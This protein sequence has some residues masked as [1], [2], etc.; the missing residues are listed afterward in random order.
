[1]RTSTSRRCAPF[2]VVAVASALF[3]AT[4]SS[5]ASPAPLA[6]GD[7]WRIM[8]PPPPSDGGRATYYD[9]AGTGR[10]DVWIVG[11]TGQTGSSHALI[12][13]W[14]GDAWTE[15]PAGGTQLNATLHSVAVVSRTNA[16]AVGWDY[17]PVQH[18]FEG[19]M[20]HWDGTSWTRQPTPDHGLEVFLN[21][22]AA[23]SSTRAIAVGE[24]STFSSTKTVAIRLRNG[25]WHS[26][27]TPPLGP[28]SSLSAVSMR[29]RADAWAVGTRLDPG[30][31]RHVVALHWDG[32]TWSD[33]GAPDPGVFRNALNGVD[34][35]A[36]NDVWAVGSSENDDA[37]RWWSAWHWDGSGWTTSELTGD[38]NVADLQAVA[39]FAPDD[40]R[41][42]GVAPFGTSPMR[43]A[44]WD[45]A[46]LVP[47]SV[48]SLRPT[49]EGHLYGAAVIGGR[50]WAVGDVTNATTFAQVRGLVARRC[51]GA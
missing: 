33:M 37:T 31:N 10:A 25:V 16:W 12:Q 7:A 50:L 17:D 18:R 11:G 38:D 14:D 27:T 21:G 23:I 13:H 24:S 41:M 29:G 30:S 15:L 19:L 40:V 26:M 39:H 9:V 35:I 4:T 44:R 47:D 48:P 2:L 6:C 46:T 36:P 3:S 22:V 51:P 45:G 43:A 49:R 5:L 20:E 8:S 32:D 28:Y 1:M 42:V 34:E